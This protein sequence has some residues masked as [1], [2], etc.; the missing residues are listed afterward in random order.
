MDA[1]IFNT[2]TI[3]ASSTLGCITQI[4]RQ[5]RLFSQLYIELFEFLLYHIW[6]MKNVVHLMNLPYESAFS[7]KV[8]ATTWL[9]ML[10]EIQFECNVCSS[11]IRKFSSIFVYICIGY[12]LLLVNRLTNIRKLI[13]ILFI[14]DICYF[15]MIPNLSLLLTFIYLSSQYKFHL[16]EGLNFFA[17]NL[18]FI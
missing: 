16:N 17:S 7:A 5:H 9:F 18:S 10:I 6:K 4:Q 8:K 14:S 2:I 13:Q 11:R 3:I 12:Q 15:R 1:S